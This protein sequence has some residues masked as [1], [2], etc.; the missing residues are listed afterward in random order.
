[1]RHREV[2]GL[3]SD[4]RWLYIQRNKARFVNRKSG[5]GVAALALLTLLVASSVSASQPIRGFATYQVSFNSPMGQRS[6]LVNETVGPS[7]KAGY[8][9]LVL[10]LLGTQQNLTYSRLVNSSEN[11]FP[12]LPNV[13]PQSLDYT[14]GTG[15]SVHVNVTS[16]GTT[17]VKFN[18]EQYTLGVL[19]ISVSAAYG[20]QSFRA[21]GTVETFPSSLVYSAS[22]G[23]GMVGLRVVLQATDLPLASS[24][25][26]TT[27]AAYVG[28]GVGIGAMALGG[29]FLIRRKERKVETQG[30]K[31]LHWVD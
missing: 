13:V 23:N 3:S 12:Y 6:L 8:S 10:Q 18:G 26:Q 11:L 21:N 22:V 7:S 27:T 5:T 24:S 15:Y 16:S 2:K 9:D 28:V 14:N 1:M 17:T 29:A 31:P 20:T 19:A 4:V 30:E 25:P